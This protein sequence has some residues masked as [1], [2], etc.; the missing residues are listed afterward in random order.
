[1]DF[2]DRHSAFTASRNLFERHAGSDRLARCALLRTGLKHT[3]W[4]VGVAER[5]FDP[6]AISGEVRTVLEVKLKALLDERLKIFYLQIEF[7]L[8]IINFLECLLFLIC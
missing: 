8:F 4:Q 6:R 5:I 2:T 7:I 3:L 1:M